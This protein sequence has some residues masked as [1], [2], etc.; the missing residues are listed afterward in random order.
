VRVDLAR[1]QPVGAL[2]QRTKKRLLRVVC[3]SAEVCM[4]THMLLLHRT[5]GPNTPKSMVPP[6]IE[7]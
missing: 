3:R 2:S 5:V 6:C 1:S 4:Q 7:Q